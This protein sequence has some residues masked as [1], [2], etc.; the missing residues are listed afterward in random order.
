MENIIINLISLSVILAGIFT[1]FKVTGISKSIISISKSLTL[2]PRKIYSAWLMQSY[3]A[4]FIQSF[5][6][7]VIFSAVLSSKY[8]EIKNK[9]K[10]VEYIEQ[11]EQEIKF[12]KLKTFAGFETIEQLR[13][14]EDDFKCDS[15][16]D[17]SNYIKRI[18][19]DK[20]LA[21]EIPKLEKKIVAQLFAVKD[22]LGNKNE[23]PTGNDREFVNCLNSIA[24]QTDAS[25]IEKHPTSPIALI[26][27][28]T[29][30]LEQ[31]LNDYKKLLD[32]RANAKKICNTVAEHKDYLKDS[33][34]LRGY[35][36]KQMSPMEYEVNV[37]GETWILQ[38]TKHSFS[39]RGNFALPVKFEGVA[40][41]RKTAAA[42]GFDAQVGVAKEDENYKNVKELLKNA[43]AEDSRF[44]TDVYPKVISNLK[45][46]EAGLSS[47]FKIIFTELSVQQEHGR[48]TASVAEENENLKPNNSFD[49][50]DF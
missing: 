38:T 37:Q 47:T 19:S 11:K 23:I 24:T 40:Q 31:T 4:R 1:I 6:G 43:Q 26:A 13:Q 12:A 46:L 25:F 9:E 49:N 7:F 20:K 34:I 10:W 42:G 30:A 21:S 15:L 45:A 18:T 32:V 44:R 36:V 27:K 16:D 35:I 29:K 14:I 5:I 2:N 28:N 17:S 50:C 39:S 41:I 3:G 8:E 48:S 33:G 22:I